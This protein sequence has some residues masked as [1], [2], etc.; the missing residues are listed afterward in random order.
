MFNTLVS[1]GMQIKISLRFHLTPGRMAKIKNSGGRRCREECG[2]RET[3]LHL[4]WDYK[5][6]QSL[7]KSICWFF[8]KLEIVLLED[9]AIPHLGIY[10]KRC[11]NM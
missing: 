1:R 4:W 9:L 3:V 8:K 7:W 2:E 6:V 10:P 11:S 5:L